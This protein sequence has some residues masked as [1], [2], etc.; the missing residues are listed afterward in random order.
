MHEGVVL[1]ELDLGECRELMRSLSVGRVAVNRADLPPLVVPVNY[2]IDG[3]TVLFR[4][5]PGTKFDALLR[6]PVSFQVDFIDPIH[7]TGWS[8]LLAG[9]C[10]PI[11]QSE[12]LDGDE[13]VIESWVVAGHQHHLV[14][15]TPTDVSGR[16]IRLPEIVLDARGYL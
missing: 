11:A 4:T 12:E 9:I 13:F 7:R 8:V 14:R 5:E 1:E 10:V 2:V 6:E 15:L 3:E 16:R